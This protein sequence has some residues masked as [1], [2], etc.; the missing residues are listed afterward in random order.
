MYFQD[1]GFVPVQEHLLMSCRHTK[2]PRNLTTKPSFTSGAQE[3]LPAETPQL[4]VPPCTQYPGYFY[5]ALCLGL[6]LFNT[7]LNTARS[8]AKGCNSNKQQRKS[9][10]KEK[11]MICGVRLFGVS[12]GLEGGL[13][14]FNNLLCKQKEVGNNVD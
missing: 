6:G 10:K 4:Q 7:H 5:H 3:L 14:L 13:N 1:R 8:C 9:Q 2:R 12:V 11:G